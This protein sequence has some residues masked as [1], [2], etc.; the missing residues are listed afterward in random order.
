MIKITS[1]SISKSKN[2][3]LNNF[4]NFF[5]EKEKKKKFKFFE[6]VNFKSNFWRSDDIKKKNKKLLIISGISRSG[7][8]LLL[9]IIDN[10]K[11]ICFC[12]GEDGIL[13]NLLAIVKS[14]GEKKTEHKLRT[15]NINFLKKLSG[16]KIVNNK[17]TLFDKW[18]KVA[19]LSKNSKLRHSGTQGINITS[20]LDFKNTIPSI[21]YSA[22]VKYLSKKT[23]IDNFYDFF[24]FY[25]EASRKLFFENKKKKF[26]YTLCHSGLRREINF[27]L[28]NNVD[29]IVLVPVR[30][31]KGFCS[32]Y[33][34]GIYRT[35]K[36]TTHQLNDIWENW[37]H[38]V[39]DF[40][41]LKEKFPNRIILIQYEDLIKDP[42]KLINKLFGKIKISKIKKIET[43]I[44]GKLNIGNS[45][46][47]LDNIKAG[48]IYK[49]KNYLKLNDKQIPDEYKKIMKLIKQ[50]KLK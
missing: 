29:A 28:S 36:P 17:I 22:F 3:S 33:L 25:L 43:T 18:L 13:R 44:L 15:L 11:D 42:K 47:N 46:F 39:I 7:N 48:K 23:I 35:E 9:S 4:K 2:F 20:I 21:N 27:L 26:Y 32:S 12:G 34:K 38:K 19:N 41:L 30:D 40:L 49:R 45:S 50:K 37:R 5:F 8:H 1:N 6:E 31:F 14:H 10:H 16:S 24:Y